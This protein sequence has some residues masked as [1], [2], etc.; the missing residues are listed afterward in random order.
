MKNVII[1]TIDY[2]DA[3]KCGG[4]RVTRG[5]TRY[6]IERESSYIGNDTGTKITCDIMPMMSD[7]DADDWG[8]YLQQVLSGECG[9]SSNAKIVTRGILVQ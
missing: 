8:E 5:R 7:W 4:I 3:Q 2:S 1:D 9:Q 6:T